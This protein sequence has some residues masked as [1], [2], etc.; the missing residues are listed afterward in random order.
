MSFLEQDSKSV[1]VSEQEL[2]YLLPVPTN[3]CS[4]YNPIWITVKHVLYLAC[5]TEMTTL[6]T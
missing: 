5:P 1:T 2:K 3:A 4:G 6:E